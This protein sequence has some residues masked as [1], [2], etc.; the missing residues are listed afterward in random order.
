MNTK[1]LGANGLGA[2]GL[3]ANGLGVNGLSINS[4]GCAELGS[5]FRLSKIYFGLHALERL[6][7][8]SAVTIGAF[9]GVHLGHQSIISRLREGADELGVPAIAVTFFPDPA[10]YFFPDTA[11][12]QVMSWR[13]KAL[14]LLEA[15]ADAVVCLP[16]NAALRAM[17]AND[18]A[19]EILVARLGAKFILVGDDFRFGLNREGDYS[20]LQLLGVELGY[21]VERSPTVRCGGERIS[22]TRL[23]AELAAGQFD[24]AEALLGRAYEMCGRVVKGHQL[25]R[26]LGFPTANVPL[27]RDTVP[28]SGVY[29][30]TALISG[31]TYN[32]V[33]N[34]GYR[35][36]VNRLKKPLLEV[37]LLDFDN[38]IYG[39]RIRVQF[40]HKLRAEK[41]FEG[42]E[43]LQA[44][45]AEDVDVAR[46]WFQRR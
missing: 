4:L 42:L 21:E 6:T 36:A 2:N 28:L 46:R 35:P 39:E 32:G 16:F 1:N 23:R 40:H 45:I 18:F 15:G 43:Q 25:G 12:A 44:A 27:R 37:H 41:N 5:L 31:Q 10:Q 30:V 14:G 22:S 7:P 17:S 11:P 24:E 13:E 20:R 19:K 29:T 38:D 33:A 9:D 34:I 8:G 26:K 3:N